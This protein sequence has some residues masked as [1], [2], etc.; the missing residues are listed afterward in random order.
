MR[1]L[2]IVLSS[3]IVLLLL[4][5]TSYR[6]YQVWKQSH[7][8]AMAKA[9]FAKGDGRS[10]LLSLQQVLH[11]NPKNIEACRMMADLT[12]AARSPSA[13]SFWKP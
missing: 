2:I 10:T 5:Y 11:V 3:C 9:Y 13:S 7:G 4:G 8:L 6:G 12:Q 1:K